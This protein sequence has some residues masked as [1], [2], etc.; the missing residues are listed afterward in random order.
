MLVE[1][2]IQQLVPI[3]RVSQ[4]QRGAA[5]FIEAR[6]PAGMLPVHDHDGPIGLKH[7][8]GEVEVGVREDG[9]VSLEGAVVLPPDPGRIAFPDTRAV[10]VV[11]ENF[12]VASPHGVHK[13]LLGLVRARNLGPPA[14][15]SPGVV[16]VLKFLGQDRLFPDAAVVAGRGDAAQLIHVPAQLRDN[17]SPLGCR[18]SLPHLVEGFSGDVIHHD[19]GG[20]GL[21][22]FDRGLEERV[23]L[24]YRNAGRL[25]DEKRV[26]ALLDGGTVPELHGVVFV[27]ADDTILE[28]AGDPLLGGEDFR[29]GRQR[30]RE[31]LRRSVIREGRSRSHDVCVGVSVLSCHMN[32][33][34]LVGEGLGWMGK[35]ESLLVLC[36][37]QCFDLRAS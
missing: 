26:L 34:L 32:L 29:H 13:L 6:I 12:V 11:L 17:I 20:V 9:P 23:N 28:R 15:W 33:E 30:G 14:E 1:D 18:E 2:V 36:L 7:D 24:W 10:V 8:V 22:T 21:V 35:G 3:A 31:E 4:E 16:H 27:H 5:V 19:E 37:S 25:L